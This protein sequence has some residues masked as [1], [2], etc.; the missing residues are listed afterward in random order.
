M[1]W[2]FVQIILNPET[3]SAVC[4][5]DHIKP[6]WI[7]VLALIFTNNWTETTTRSS[8]CLSFCH[9]FVPLW[10][11]PIL[12]QFHSFPPVTIQDSIKPYNFNTVYVNHFLD[13][14]HF[15]S[16]SSPFR[17]P[18]PAFEGPPGVVAVLPAIGLG[19]LLGV[20]SGVVTLGTAVVVGAGTAAG[21]DGETGGD[22]D[23]W[24]FYMAMDQYLLIPFLEGWTS[25]YQLFWCSPGVQGF[26]PLPYDFMG[27][28]WKTI[29]L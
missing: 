8:M 3:T 6:C 21:G 24:W 10:I 12:L 9:H 5:L 13:I 15:P 11:I 17:S 4:L 26:D 27:I 16:I 28:S 19:G 25:I 2:C 14:Q 7:H 18:S 23:E 1:D 22:L 29:I 20:A